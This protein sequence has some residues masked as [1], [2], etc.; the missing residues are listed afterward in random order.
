VFP[1][2]SVREVSLSTPLPEELRRGSRRSRVSNA[3]AVIA[4]GSKEELGVSGAD[5]LG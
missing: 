1:L 4:Y 3:R 2:A 5:I